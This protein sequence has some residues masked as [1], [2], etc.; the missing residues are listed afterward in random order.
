[1][2]RKICTF[3]IGMTFTIKLNHMSLRKFNDII[4]RFRCYYKKKTYFSTYN[5]WR[6]VTRFKIISNRFTSAYSGLQVTRDV[7]TRFILSVFDGCSTPGRHESVLI[8]NCNYYTT[9]GVRITRQLKLLRVR[10]VKNGNT[11]ISCCSCFDK[12]VLRVSM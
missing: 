12:H 4:L 5:L 6:K 10:F 9:P 7:H 3:L 2:Y 11:R 8:N 1:M